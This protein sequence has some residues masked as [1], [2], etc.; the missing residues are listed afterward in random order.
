MESPT[1]EMDPAALRGFFERRAP[2]GSLKGLTYFAF[3]RARM[4]ERMERGEDDQLKT[5]VVLV[6]LFIE[7]TAVDL[8]LIHI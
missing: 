6:A 3:A 4:W 8:S 2:L 1:S 7:Q 5:L